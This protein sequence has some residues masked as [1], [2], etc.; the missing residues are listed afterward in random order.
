MDQ[1][2]LPVEGRGEEA[3]GAGQ[4][5]QRVLTDRPSA[6][7]PLYWRIGRQDSQGSGPVDAILSN[8]P[9]E[10]GFI[11]VAPG[12]TLFFDTY[13][14][15]FFES[16]WRLN[17]R[18]RRLSLS[19][20]VTG[21]CMVRVKR[22]SVGVDQLLG[23]AR[24]GSGTRTL[25][26]A[27]P[28]I[29]MNFR[30]YGLL[31]FEVTALGPGATFREAAWLGTGP[32]APVAMGIV[33][34]TFNRE[35]FIAGVLAAMVADPAVLARLDRIVV[36]NQ[37][38]TGLRQHPEIAPLAGQLGGRL[39]IIEQN[40]FGGAGGFTRGLLATLEDPALTHCAL[41]DDDI[42]LEPDTILRLIAFLSLAGE[43]AV[44]GQM[45]DGVRPT[46]LYENGAV[47]DSRD[48]FPKPSQ[49]D[50]D[51]LDPDGLDLLAQPQPVHFNGWWC[52]ALSLDI[53]RR[54]GLPLPCFIRGDDAE[55]GMRLYRSGVPTIVLPGAAVWHEPFYLKLN[56]WQLY[57]ETRNLLVLA[58]LHDRFSPRAALRRAGRNWLIHLLTFRYYGA[59][60]IG[61]GIADFL[62]GPQIL[63]QD[64]QALHK[65]VVELR[66]TYGPVQVGRRHVVDRA[67]VARMPRHRLGFLVLFTIVLL[68]NALLPTAR[69]NPVM[70]RQGEFS[71]V[72]LRRI[73]RYVLDNW[74]E[75]ELS[76]YRRDR[77]TFWTLAWRILPVMAQLLTRGSRVAA[78]WQ[79]ASSELTST[80]FWN[81]Y[82][83]RAGSEP[84]PAVTDRWPSMA[85]DRAAAGPAST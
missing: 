83:G 85:S 71:W 25:G 29:S 52:F 54:T 81:T 60:L 33:F 79:A 40:N 26:F 36:V 21:P 70:V 24:T 37:G 7:R 19:V 13:F 46:R 31:F 2:A 49:H 34:C 55:Y 20:T 32:A 66:T 56:G 82:L 63:R 11:S 9:G 15:A 68:R 75:P 77:G 16:H 3:A 57:Y 73:D 6:L 12:T 44:G 5:L 72:G 17:T 1:V 35:R 59:A 22:R 8:E 53:V 42:R 65:G 27:I 18:M 48:W 43:V 23:E 41:L 30:E 80:R 51:L 45:L 4:V 78:S 67:V 84:D 69:S 61:R 74:W 39:T 50:L 38:R 76:T 64:P 62:Q 28:D 10:G 14:G 58:A 47:I